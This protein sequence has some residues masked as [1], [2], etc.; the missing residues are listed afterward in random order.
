MLLLGG[1]ALSLR[2]LHTAKSRAFSAVATAST[3]SE[4][5]GNAYIFVNA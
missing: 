4:A 5:P 2:R 1:T 3:P